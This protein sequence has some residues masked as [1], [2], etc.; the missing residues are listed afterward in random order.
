MLKDNTSKNNEK[1][2]QRGK[3][4]GLLRLLAPTLIGVL[5]FTVCLCGTTWAWF[6]ATLQGDVAEIQAAS[7]EISVTVENSDTP[8]AT[9]SSKKDGAAGMSY[10]LDRNMT[11][12]VTIESTGS[13]KTGHCIV[14]LGDAEYPTATF[15]SIEN[16]SLK[17]QV[18]SDNGATLSFA[19]YCWGTYSGNL[20]KYITNGCLLTDTGVTTVQ[21]NDSSEPSEQTEEST[22]AAPTTEPTGDTSADPTE[23]QQLATEPSAEPVTEAT[24]EAPSASEPEAPTEPNA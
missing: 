8:V 1:R 20:T 2:A 12:T 18:R 3:G 16:G 10:Q 17:F 6:S 15:P 23:A 13:A 21:Q 19:D 4:D 5:I 24:T 14:K 11:Y 22:T 9:F 7:F